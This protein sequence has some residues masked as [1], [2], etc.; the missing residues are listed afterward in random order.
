MFYGGG[1]VIIVLITQVTKNQSR[2]RLRANNN[3]LI[4]HVTS[5]SLSCSTEATA[6][7]SSSL[8]RYCGHVTSSGPMETGYLLLPAVFITVTLY[9]SGCVF[10]VLIAQVLRSCDILRT[11]WNRLFYATPSLS[12][13]RSTEAAAYSLSSLLR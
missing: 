5:L 12:L 1:S 8:P 3:R 2:D 7:S 11:N 13:S 10:I 9:G 6:Y 4:N